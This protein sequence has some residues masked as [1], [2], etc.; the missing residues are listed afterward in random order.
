MSRTILRS[1]PS[2]T[3]RSAG[4]W[5]SPSPGSA[6]GEVRRHSFSSA[7]TA[8]VAS[9]PTWSGLRSGLGLGLGL[10][11][12]VGLGLG[13]GLGLAPHAHRAIEA[14]GDDGVG[15]GLDRDDRPRVADH[16]AHAPAPRPL[17][18]VPLPEVSV[19]AA[20]ERALLRGRRVEPQP[21][22]ALRV[23][24]ESVRYLVRARVRLPL[25]RVVASD[26]MPLPGTRPFARRAASPCDGSGPTA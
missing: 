18:Q 12:G 13:L 6:A 24:L 5:L 2:G 23:P 8:S 19:E 11:L 22:D 1:S 14:R 7:S 26:H 3:R 17:A 4:S 16:R 20:R 25:T 15:R 9:A 21:Q 10:G